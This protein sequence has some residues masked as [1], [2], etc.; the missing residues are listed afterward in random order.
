MPRK[1]SY[2]RDDLIRRARDV[3][4]KQGWAGTSLKDLE[5]TLNLKPGSFYAAFGSKD[6]LYQ[7]TLDQYAKDGAAAL[8]AL[9]QDRGP[10]GA[11][12]AYP[13]HIIENDAAAAR[14]CMLVKTMLELSPHDH[15]LADHA[16]AHLNTMENRFSALF[17][18]AQDNQEI[19]DTHDPARLA[20]RYQSD[21][22]GMRISAERPGHDSASTIDEIEQSLAR[23]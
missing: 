17:S 14:A 18:A 7:L 21:L 2:D 3:F 8:E 10:L 15:P 11:L 22:L 1:P 12:Q 23:L 4:W 6:A 5:K 13:R 19:G 16:N 9:A 20:R